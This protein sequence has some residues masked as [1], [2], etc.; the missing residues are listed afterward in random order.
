[1]TTNQRLARL[2]RARGLSV[3]AVAAMLDR[4]EHTVR[5]WLKPPTSKSHRRCP[6]YAVWYLETLKRTRAA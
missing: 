4:S 2:M 5:A 1:M 3:R 6:K